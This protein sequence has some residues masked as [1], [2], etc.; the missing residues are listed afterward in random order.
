MR[1]FFRKL[2]WLL[3]R[4]R[5]EAELRE[6][7][8]FHLDEETEERR[9]G[10]FTQEKARFEARRDLGNMTLIQEDTR[11]AWSWVILERLGQDVR[12]SLRAARKQQSIHRPRRFVTGVRHRGK[13]SYF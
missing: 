12:Y 6:E 1:S 3:N 9:V 11:A 13:H 2:N 5:K 4:R 8:E 7:I 10:G